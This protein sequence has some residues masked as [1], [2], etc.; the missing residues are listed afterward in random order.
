MELTKFIP[1]L[2]AL[3]EQFFFQQ[4]GFIV[5]EELLLLGRDLS[6]PL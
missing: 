6:T 3:T 1:Q 5:H 2:Y 4:L